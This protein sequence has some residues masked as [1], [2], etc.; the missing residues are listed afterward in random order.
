ML[1]KSH[2]FLSFTSYRKKKLRNITTPQ[3]H[4]LINTIKPQT[5]KMPFKIWSQRAREM[6][7]K[8]KHFAY[9]SLG[10]PAGHLFHAHSEWEEKNNTS[11]DLKVIAMM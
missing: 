1:N 11:Y 3:V 2:H 9:K 10:S 5:F 8:I 4:P 6:A 7:Q